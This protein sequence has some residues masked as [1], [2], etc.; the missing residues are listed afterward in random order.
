VIFLGYTAFKAPILF[1]GSTIFSL[2]VGEDEPS[3]W[4]SESDLLVSLWLADVIDYVASGQ[5][6]LDA[7]TNNSFSQIL[8]SARIDLS[9][10]SS[11]EL[12]KGPQDW[13]PF[14]ESWLP[15]VSFGYNSD[16]LFPLNKDR[17]SLSISSLYSSLGGIESSGYNS[18]VSFPP[19]KDRNSLSI[20]SLDSSL[21]GIE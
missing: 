20:S 9:V 21:G 1:S 19:H 17:N 15:M 12:P 4:N 14:S 5:S 18:D 13:L 6:L 8:S 3:T 2:G 16:V 10:F 11:I 7:S